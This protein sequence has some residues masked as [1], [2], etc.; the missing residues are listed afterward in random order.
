MDGKPHIVILGG[1]FGGVYTAFHLDRMLRRGKLDAEVTLVSRENFYLMTPLLFEA[2]SGVLEPRHAVNPIRRMVRVAQFVEMEV[3]AVD[4][5]QRRVLGR[6]TP[7]DPPYH[8]PYDHLVLALGGVSNRRLIPGSEHAIAFK[9]MT[10]ALRLRN[11]VV[12]MFERADV[13]RD[14]RKKEELLTFV[15]IGG[16]LVGV[17]LMGELESFATKLVRPYPHIRHAELRF[18]LL[19]GGNHIVEEMPKDLAMY[20]TRKFQQRGIQ[21]RN[22]THVTRI[23]PGRALLE[24]GETITS[25]TILLATGVAPNPLVETLPLEKTRKGRIVTNAAMRVPGRPNLW[26]L[27]DCAAV[28]DPEGKPFPTLA[29]HA[30][31]QAK[32]LANNLCAATRG[33]ETRIKP[34]VYHTQGM[35][36]ALGDYSGIAKVKGV[37]LRGFLAWWVWRSYYL[38][39]MPRWDRRLRLIIDWTVALIFANDIVKI[40]VYSENNAPRQ[41]DRTPSPDVGNKPQG[42]AGQ[43]A[44]DPS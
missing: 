42:K 21:I 26:A 8:L 34:F 12:D 31:R 18:I 40:G 2:S 36:A 14:P 15:V 38:W 27:G 10:D 11:H 37:K 24:G 32:V 28:P 25:R 17:E 19:D 9:T 5:E 4:F 3:E 39:Q 33:E 43:S 7:S 41:E 30:L 6:H 29:Q 22:H 35:L 13:E 16:G 23:E 1:G 44:S 20:A